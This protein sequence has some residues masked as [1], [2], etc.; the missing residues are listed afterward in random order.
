MSDT[1][2]HL[3]T[4]L[5]EDYYTVFLHRQPLHCK[6]DHINEPF[7]AAG[8]INSGKFNYLTSIYLYSFSLVVN[9]DVGY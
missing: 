6:C 8:F 1:M 2:D 7:H 9:I 3:C 4:T 5:S